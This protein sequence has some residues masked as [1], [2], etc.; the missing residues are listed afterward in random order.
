MFRHPHNPCFGAAIEKKLLHRK[1]QLA[2]RSEITESAFVISETENLR[3]A[4]I[5]PAF[6]ITN[7]GRDRCGHAGNGVDAAWDF[8]DINAGI[9]YCGRH[10]CPFLSDDSGSCIRCRAWWWS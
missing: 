5:E 1:A 10:D 2:V 9:T 6:G 3:R 7:K 4:I 8:F